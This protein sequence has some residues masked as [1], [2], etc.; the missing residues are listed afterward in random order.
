MGKKKK[1]AEIE[2]RSLHLP[3][4]QA[5]DFGSP[6]AVPCLSE[7]LMSRNHNAR[8]FCPRTAPSISVATH[9]SGKQKGDKVL[10]PTNVANKYLTSRADFIG[11]GLS[12]CL[13]KAT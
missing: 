1:D 13:M 8:Y 6:A 12:S 9:A 10:H 3:S 2:T 11:T 5:V 7:V 4:P